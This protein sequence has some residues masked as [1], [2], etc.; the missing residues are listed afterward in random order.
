MAVA[1]WS[2]RGPVPVGV[3][4]KAGGGRGEALTEH[5]AGLAWAAQQSLP[6]M[7]SSPSAVLVHDKLGS[8]DA[9]HKHTLLLPKTA[10]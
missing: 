10:A 2:L 8:D 3:S 7:L 9:P 1:V 4:S 5:A 6:V